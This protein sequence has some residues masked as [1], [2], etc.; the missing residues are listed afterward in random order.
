MDIEDMVKDA[1]SLP[2][3]GADTAYAVLKAGNK[4]DK[5]R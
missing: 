5:R 3:Q 2:E 1:K 4:Y